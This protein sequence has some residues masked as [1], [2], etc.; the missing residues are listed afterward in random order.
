MKATA[1]LRHTD[2]VAARASETRSG[3]PE[4]R[5]AFLF[6]GPDQASACHGCSQGDHGEGWNDFEAGEVHTAD[7]DG[8]HL[9]LALA[10]A[11]LAGELLSLIHI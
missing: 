2:A 8:D 10:T 9:R 3:F 6:L 4:H 11:V 7:V 1:P 5:N